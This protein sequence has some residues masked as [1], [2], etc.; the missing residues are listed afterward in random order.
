MADSHRRYLF[1]YRHEGAEWAIEVA[2]R[3]LQDAKARLQTLPRSLYKGEVTVSG[4]I[5][6][7]ESNHPAAQQY[8]VAND[9]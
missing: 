3:D 7:A 8:H 2:A 4:T 6:L 5:P 1:E 9:L